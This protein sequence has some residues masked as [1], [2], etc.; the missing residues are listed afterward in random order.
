MNMHVNASK[1][2][3]DECIIESCLLLD[4]LQ[5]G[6][7]SLSDFNIDDTFNIKINSC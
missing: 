1:S 5:K 7:A 3:Q 2:G 6:R 4:L